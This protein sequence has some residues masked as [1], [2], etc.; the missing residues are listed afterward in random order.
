MSQYLSTI[1]KDEEEESMGII[2]MEISSESR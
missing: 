2:C 1:R